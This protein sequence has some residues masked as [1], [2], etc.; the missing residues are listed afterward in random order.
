MAAPG[1]RGESDAWGLTGI[2]GTHVQHSG[3]GAFRIPDL[4]SRSCPGRHCGTPHFGAL[5]ATAV[6]LPT[7]F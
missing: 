7:A 6:T 2:V 4:D 3:A 1:K 5:P